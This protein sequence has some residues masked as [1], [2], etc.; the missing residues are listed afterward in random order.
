ML[1]KITLNVVL[2]VLTSATPLAQGLVVLLVLIGFT[3]LHMVKMPYSN[4]LLNRI[5]MGSLLLSCG[6]LYAGL[7]L[8]DDG[9]LV[10]LRIMITVVMLTAMFLAAMIFMFVLCRHVQSSRVQT[11]KDALMKLELVAARMRPSFS[12]SMRFSGEIEASSESMEDELTVH[13]NPLH[14]SMKLKRKQKSTSDV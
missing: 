2:V 11:A 13:A 4:A 12:T 10:G 6:V 7:F 9:L 5:E 3:A 14:K 1:R 8:F